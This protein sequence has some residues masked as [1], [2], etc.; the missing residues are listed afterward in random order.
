ML[1][2]CDAGRINYFI[3]GVKYGEHIL[4]DLGCAFENVSPFG[5]NADGCG[6]GGAGQGAPSGIDGGRTGRYPANGAVRP[7]AL[8]PVIGLRH[9]GD[10][11]TMSSKW[12]TTHGADGAA[13]M[14]NALA[15]DEVLGAY[16]RPLTSLTPKTSPSSRLSLPR[17][18]VEESFHECKL[19]SITSTPH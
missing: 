4:N 15:V 14:R 6:S 7:K 1:L 13:V 5:F 2:D 8:W 16:E 9:P 12:M 3:D 11:V 17:W 10:R 18:F 19:M